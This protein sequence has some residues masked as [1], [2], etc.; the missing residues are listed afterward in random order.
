M[1]PCVVQFLRHGS[2]HDIQ[3]DDMNDFKRMDS[4][5]SA[6]GMGEDEKLAIYV[7]VAGVLHLGNVCFEENH[8]DSRGKAYTTQSLYSVCDF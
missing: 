6:M 5:M 2:L 4:A 3:L 7:I 1:C 8:E